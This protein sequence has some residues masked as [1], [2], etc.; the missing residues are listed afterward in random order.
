MMRRARSL[1]VGL[2]L[3]ALGAQAIAQAP[4]RDA[5]A[6]DDAIAARQERLEQADSP[7]RLGPLLVEQAEAL[8]ARLAMDA[9]DSAA[10]VGLPTQTQRERAGQ[11]AARAMELLESGAEALNRGVADLAADPQFAESREIQDLRSRLNVEY[12]LLRVPA[13]RARAALLLAA[14]E[15]DADRADTYAR[16]AIQDITPLIADDPDRRAHFAVIY[17]LALPVADRSDA[18]LDRALEALRSALRLSRSVPAEERSERVIVEASLGVAITLAMGGDIDEAR[19]SVETLARRAPFQ[20]AGG[21]PHPVWAMLLRDASSRIEARAMSG[22]GARARLGAAIAP[23]VAF[24]EDDSGSWSEA[25]RLGIAIEKINT[26]A[27]DFD[28]AALPAAARIARARRVLD[29]DAQEGGAARALAL[30]DPVLDR[31]AIAPRALAPEALYTALRA[32]ER[33]RIAASAPA[34]ASRH[35]MAIFRIGLRIAVDHPGAPGADSALRAICEIGRRIAPEWGALNTN[36]ATGAAESARDRWRDALRLCIDRFEGEE[37]DRCRLDLARSLGAASSE[38]GALLEQV[39]LSG[40]RGVEAAAMRARFAA[41]RFKDAGESPDAA[42]ALLAAIERISAP[43]RN[44][45]VRAP[46]RYDEFVP[47]AA[48]MD[49]LR[50]LGRFEEAAD[51]AEEAARRGEA[52]ARAGEAV[53]DAA[54]RLTGAL[55]DRLIGAVKRSDAA[56]IDWIAPLLARSA[57]AG[58][59][60]TSRLT[61]RAAAGETL[62]ARLGKALLHDDRPG[63]AARVLESVVRASGPPDRALDLAAA[64]RGA[65]DDAESFALLRDLTERLERASDRSDHFWRAWTLMLEILAARNDDGTR[66]DAIRRELQRLR[67]I[68]PDLGGP[69]W[70]ERLGRVAESIEE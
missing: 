12:R 46:D 24:L 11:G 1:G 58:L 2:A 9:A 21:G 18:A 69:P 3:A 47:G 39:D 5:A 48:E 4:S 22:A 15:D 16:S 49:A 25:Q 30:L 33:A 34:E 17:G 13:A 68:D 35:L 20:R 55:Q 37:A 70:A 38:A 51:V 41:R 56:A 64:R 31:D 52:P 14:L 50:A 26:I 59:D 7:V 19:R 8:L 27:R 43:M 57:R 40:D 6:L 65:G 32:R 10:L 53:L 23:W 66:T 29:D 61:G 54:I 36:A 44:E 63:E 28:D 60:I 42:E 67:L 62:A 45:I